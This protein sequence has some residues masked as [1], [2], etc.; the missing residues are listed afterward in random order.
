MVETSGLP[1]YE[2]TRRF[3]DH[4]GHDQEARIR[5]FHAVGE[6]KVVFWKRLPG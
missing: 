1:E 5:D 6:D 4:I 2:R 3:Y